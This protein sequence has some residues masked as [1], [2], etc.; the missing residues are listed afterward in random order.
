MR[1]EMQR[2]GKGGQGGRP[3]L[4]EWGQRGAGG[5]G[6]VRSRGHCVSLGPWRGRGSQS[7]RVECSEGL[8]QSNRVSRGMWMG[9]SFRGLHP[10]GLGP[11]DRPPKL[12]HQV[13]NQFA[14]LSQDPILRGPGEVHFRSANT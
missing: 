10:L 3:Q 9:Y 12:D 13:L 4:E 2:P 6:R 11:R 1:V 14:H 7:Q 8:V 5:P